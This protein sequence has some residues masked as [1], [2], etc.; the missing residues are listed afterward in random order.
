MGAPMSAPRAL[1]Q[2][3]PKLVMLVMALALCVKALV[4]SGYMV[5]SGTTELLTVALCSQGLDA[6]KTATIAIHKEGGSQDQDSEGGKTDT[7]CAF[8]ALSMVSLGGA[9][10]PL[11]AMAL[12]FILALGLAP[13][14]A[15]LP[16]E[17]AYLRPP[18][19]GPPLSI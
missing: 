5:R 1:I 17:P 10:A 6:P 14:A 4:P 16:A 12:L 2:R 9:D 11:L 3:Q 13:S 18:L 8:T 19:R 15:P 7:P